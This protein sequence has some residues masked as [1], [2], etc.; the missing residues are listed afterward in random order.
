[1]PLRRQLVTKSCHW[2]AK[3]TPWHACGLGMAAASSFACSRSL[4]Q[5]HA[6]VCYIVY[7]YWWWMS[8]FNDSVCTI[9]CDSEPGTTQKASF[10]TVEWFAKMTKALVLKTSLN[11]MMAAMPMISKYPVTVTVFYAL[12][13]WWPWPWP[14]PCHASDSSFTG[15]HLCFLINYSSPRGLGLVVHVPSG[16]V[17]K[18]NIPWPWP[19]PWPEPLSIGPMFGMLFKCWAKKGWGWLFISL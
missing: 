1:M 14:W 12:Y 3:I 7:V 11:S 13:A 4:S 18:I 8:T 16:C 17:A 10:I 6:C 5:N 15:H 2:D 9:D 19:W